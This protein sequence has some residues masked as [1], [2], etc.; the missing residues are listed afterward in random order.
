MP[1]RFRRRIRFARGLR[2]NIGRRGISTSLGEH[3]ARVTVGSGGTRTT[4]S[5][6]IPGVSYTTSIARRRRRRRTVTWGQRIVGA[7]LVLG[8]GLWMGWLL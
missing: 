1:F 4:V 7:A 6:P 2:L 5:A 3:G 8:L